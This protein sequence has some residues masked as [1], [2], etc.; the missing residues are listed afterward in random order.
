MYCVVG[1]EWKKYCVAVCHW[2]CQMSAKYFEIKKKQKKKTTD[3]NITAKK[4]KRS[5]CFFYHIL[6]RLA[7]MALHGHHI[8]C[9]ILLQ[10]KSFYVFFTMPRGT[11]SSLW[12]SWQDLQIKLDRSLYSHAGKP[13]TTR[14]KGGKTQYIDNV[15][16]RILHEYVCK[17]T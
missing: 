10:F 9:L 12:E 14:S 5:S 6:T 13:R 2:R 7:M 17:S 15:A 8:N 4:L 11:S 16:L 1:L 3:W